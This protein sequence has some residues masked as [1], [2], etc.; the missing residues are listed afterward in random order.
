MK[1]LP[2]EHSTPAQPPKKSL[3][4]SKPTSKPLQDEEFKDL[5]QD[6]YSTANEESMIATNGESVLVAVRV[7]PMNNTELSRGDDCC[8]KVFNERELQIYQK[9]SQKLYQFNSVMQEATRQ[10]EVF[11]RCSISVIYISLL[12]C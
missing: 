10:D 2:S 12:I 4:Q 6:A 5:S 3:P 11:M 7:R 8:L 1:K 9:G